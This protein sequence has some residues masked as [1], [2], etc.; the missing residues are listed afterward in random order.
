MGPTSCHLR[1]ILPTT[2]TQLQILRRWVLRKR[3]EVATTI[4]GCIF[5]ITTLEAIARRSTNM[6]SGYTWKKELRH[7]T[8]AHKGAGLTGNKATIRAIH[9]SSIWPHVFPWAQCQGSAQQPVRQDL[10]FN[11]RMRNRQPL[12]LH[13]VFFRH[14]TWC[15]HVHI[16]C[17][18][19]PNQTSL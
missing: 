7:V 13:S 1:C 15:I 6:P 17:R 19:A 5:L 3:V 18:T 14:V 4:C 8:T 9:R 11:D 16:S 12:P 10:H 2:T